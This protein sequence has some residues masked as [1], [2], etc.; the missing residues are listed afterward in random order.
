MAG[1]AQDRRRARVS[2]RARSLPPTPAGPLGLCDARRQ[3]AAR[4]GGNGPLP[5]CCTGGPRASVIRVRGAGRGKPAAVGIALQAYD[6]G[7]R[8][9]CSCDL[10]PRH[11]AALRGR[12]G[13]QPGPDFAT[14]SGTRQELRRPSKVRPHNPATSHPHAPTMRPAPLLL[15][16]MAALLARPA[17]ATVCDDCMNFLFDEKS[18][19]PLF[20][21]KDIQI[22]NLGTIPFQIACTAV[23]IPQ[24]DL[25]DGLKG[26]AAA[27]AAKRCGASWRR[28]AAE[29]QS[30]ILEPEERLTIAVRRAAPTLGGALTLRAGNRGFGGQGGHA[31]IQ[32]QGVRAVVGRD[33]GGAFGPRGCAGCRC[34]RGGVAQAATGG[35]REQ[36]VT[37]GT[38]AK[39]AAA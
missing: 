21:N 32:L 28:Q 12:C 19:C 26:V 7:W 14:T 35:P 29:N 6:P 3:R 8:R 10:R 11:Q 5:R 16:L 2:G 22:R 36:H 38:L 9:A 37:N 23:C 30:L 25:V 27:V 18:T 1:P 17:R 20:R 13:G 24:I 31:G 34:G 39:A 33:D 15:G 4:R